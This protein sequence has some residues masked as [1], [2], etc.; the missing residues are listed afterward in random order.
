M[1]GQILCIGGGTARCT[2]WSRGLEEDGYLVVHASDEREASALLK[3][4]PVDVICI[5]SR[6]MTESGSSEIAAGLKNA[7]QHVPVVLVQTGS[8]V[9]EHFEEHVDVV[10]DE[11]TFSTVGSWLIEELREV[12]FPMFVEWFETGKERSS[13][14]GA[15][16][17]PVY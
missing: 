17:V 2:N 8:D 5:D 14:N 12:R 15:D 10:I 1:N 4:C 6:I 7:L 3:A 9:L 16:A 13:R 11:S